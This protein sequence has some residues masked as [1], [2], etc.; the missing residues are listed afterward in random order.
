MRIVCATANAHKVGE[1]AAIL[2]EVVPGRLDLVPRPPDVPAVVEDAGTLEGNAALKARAVSLATGAPAL[3]DDTGLFVEAL[4]GAPG[5]DAAYFAG[6]DATDA[7]NRARL[8][9]AL[10]GAESR[11][12]RFE[13]VALVAWPDGSITIG[14][15]ACAG[16]IATEERGIDGFGYDAVFVPDEGDGRTFGE[17]GAVGKHRLSHRRRAL[18]ALTMALRDVL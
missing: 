2:A 8:L 18:V 6:P 16:T 11:A 12:A 13:T 1:I 15:G 5:V 9:D 7:Q 14:R 10:D 4:G 3:A 17:M